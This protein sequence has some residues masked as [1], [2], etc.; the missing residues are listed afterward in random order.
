MYQLL[1]N[2]NEII[3]VIYTLIRY[4][5]LCAPLLILSHFRT[6]HINFGKC[7]IV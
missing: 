4:K 5:Y 1:N 6:L 7:E 3:I 2:N